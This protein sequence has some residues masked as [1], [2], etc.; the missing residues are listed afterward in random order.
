MIVRG[1][2]D[3]LA[4]NALVWVKLVGFGH[5]PARILDE[6]AAE[7]QANP[8]AKQA[9]HHILIRTF[10]DHVSMSVD[11]AT[12]TALGDSATPPAPVPT[13]RQKSKLYQAALQEASDAA[14]QVPPATTESANASEEAS[15]S[16]RKAVA[17]ADST[18]LSQYEKQR[19]ANMQSNQAYLVSIGLEQASADMRTD[20]QARKKRPREPK[21]KLPVAPTR[22]SGRLSGDYLPEGMFGGAS[23]DALDAM[24][25]KAARTFSG[26]DPLKRAS[27]AARISPEQ[28][29]KL[30]GLETASAG[31]LTE[32]ELRALELAR[33]DL[34]NERTE[35]GWKAHKSKGTSLYGEKRA[36]LRQAAATH[37]LRWPS[38]LDAI[39][40]VHRAWTRI[41]LSPTSSGLDSHP[42][43]QDWTLAPSP[44]F[45]MPPAMRLALLWC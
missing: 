21:P 31:P 26:L 30:D 18:G 4:P 32:A 34:V 38:W 24:E 23:L 15:G 27:A 8:C 1:I 40:E 11:P 19:L 42:P 28:S 2:M 16:A 5:W 10:G 7:S 36:I 13:K 44:P 12:L 35:G 39:Q 25:E 3:V 22:S 14:G 9:T 37:G 6:A 43:H 29:A 20:K 33:D 41:G 45:P 17:T